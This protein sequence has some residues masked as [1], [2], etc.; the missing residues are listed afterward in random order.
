MG[1]EGRGFVEPT[2]F[3]HPMLPGVVFI[4]P[5]AHSEVVA[6]AKGQKDAVILP[7]VAVEEHARAHPECVAP[8][9]VSPNERRG[10]EAPAIS[11]VRDLI[12]PALFPRL[13]QMFSDAEPTQDNALVTQLAAW[14]I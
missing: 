11:F 12:S 6:R 2:V 5:V 3:L 9:R 13:V 4:S 1:G 8:L 7:F 10:R 14:W